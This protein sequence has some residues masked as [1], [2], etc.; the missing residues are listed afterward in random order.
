RFLEE[1]GVNIPPEADTALERLDA[2]G[3][4]AV[5]VARDGVV[6]G[7]IGARDR[8]RPD[9]PAVLAALRELGIS[10]IAM[11][12]GDRSAAAAPV[13][14]AL[15]IAEVHAELLPEQKVAVLEK[16]KQ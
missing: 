15:E 7:M 8:L 3:Q 11:L 2:S 12:T 10:R 13:A 5:L 6:L 9:A 14:R 16:W 4:T 1:R